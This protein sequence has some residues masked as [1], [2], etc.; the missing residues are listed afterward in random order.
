MFWQVIF[1]IGVNREKIKK[2]LE[3][4]GLEVIMSIHKYSLS[5][6]TRILPI[7]VLPLIFSCMT[8][9]SHF[10]RSYDV[11]DK[12]ENYQVLTGYQYYRNGHHHSPDAVVGVRKGYT[13]NSPI[14]HPVSMDEKMMRSLIDRMLNNPCAEYNSEPNG[15]RIYN[16]RGDLVG[17]YY[18]VWTLPLITFMSDT[19]FSISQP[20]AVFSSSNMGCDGVEAPVSHP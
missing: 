8:G 5:I 18:S 19:E 10:D 17:V 16:D 1:C 4:L 14:W 9:R 11:S 15:S 2:S 20:M 7:L 13:L 3:Y 12:F 6:I